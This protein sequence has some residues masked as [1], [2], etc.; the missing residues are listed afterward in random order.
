MSPSS[1]A[2]RLFFCRAYAGDNSYD[3]SSSNP[4]HVTI[5]AAPTSTTMSGVPSS[6]VAAAS[7]QINGLVT[8]SS[9]GVAPTGTLQVLNNGVP[10]GGPVIVQGT[11]SNSTSPAGAQ[12]TIVATLPVGNDSI[13]VKYSGDVNYATST[14]TAATVSVSDF[15]V[16]ANPSPI[17]ISAPGQGGSSTITVTPISDFTGTVN[18]TVTGGCP[19]GATCTFSPASVAPN[20]V[21]AA[22][23]TLT[24]TTSAPPW[25]PSQC[26]RGHRQVSAFLL[27][28]SGLRWRC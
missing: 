9:N 12:A 4:L 19:T 26:P 28:S 10:L 24:I 22:T 21:S 5:S 13:S 15:S 2:G 14:S 1:L 11:A 17:N 25:P 27:A 8:T 3:A 6:T 16:S 23:S 18:L 20:G 7:T